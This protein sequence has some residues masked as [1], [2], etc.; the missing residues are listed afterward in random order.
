LRPHRIGKKFD[1][2]STSAVGRPPAARAGQ[3]G[4]HV[5]EILDRRILIFDAQ[6]LGGVVGALF[7]RAEE[8]LNERTGNMMM[9]GSLLE[10]VRSARQR[11]QRRAPLQQRIASFFSS[12]CRLVERDA[13]KRP[14]PSRQSFR[15]EFIAMC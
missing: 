2:T 9:N 11:R 8:G 5:V 12:P 7:E 1:T 4:L 14:H 13:G 3:I 6:R 15:A 10:P